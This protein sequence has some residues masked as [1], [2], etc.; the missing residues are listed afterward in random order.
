MLLARHAIFIAAIGMALAATG[1][2]GKVRSEFV[3]GCVNGGATKAQCKCAFGTL[4]D[5]YGTSGLK[6]I[7]EYGTFPPGFGEAM[8]EAVA[9]CSAKFQGL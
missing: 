5:R 3:A 2:T 4:E 1:C 8:V 7:N 9:H 6:Q